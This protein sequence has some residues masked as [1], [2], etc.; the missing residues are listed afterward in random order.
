MKLRYIC[1]IYIFNYINLANYE[2]TFN[3]PSPINTGTRYPCEWQTSTGTYFR[4]TDSLVKINYPARNYSN[5]Y[6]FF[7][8]YIHINNYRE[9]FDIKI[10]NNTY[11]GIRGKIILKI[12]TTSEFTIYINFHSAYD[13][14]NIYV[15]FLTGYS[16]YPFILNRY[17]G[18]QYNFSSYYCFNDEFRI[19]MDLTD[20]PKN[21]KHFFYQ[22]FKFKDKPGYKLYESY[23]SA[24]NFNYVDFDGYL[25]VDNNT[26]FI[27]EKTNDKYNYM[28]LYFKGKEE[29]EEYGT[30]LRSL[31]FVHLENYELFSFY[32]IVAYIIALLYIILTTAFFY[33]IFRYEKRPKKIIKPEIQKREMEQELVTQQ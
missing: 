21:K 27:V 6:L 10:F 30:E 31:N 25:D 23:E 32:P 26:V 12:N 19:I 8:Y 7:D 20:F 9:A 15:N 13:I 1:F 5:F 28:V 4:Y 24:L 2:Y 33:C 22:S 14:Y 17:W 11:Y 29:Y 16:V 18:L 3:I